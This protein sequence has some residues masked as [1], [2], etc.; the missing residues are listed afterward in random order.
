MNKIQLQKKMKMKFGS[1]SNFAR[2]VKPTD[3][4]YRYELQK[5]FARVAPSV[6]ELTKIE[7]L[8]T[9]T[10]KKPSYRNVDKAKIA[11][12]V[13]KVNEAGGPVKF[14]ADNVQFNLE[15]VKHIMYKG[16]TVMGK[17]LRELFDHFEIK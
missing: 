10:D 5:L 13:D 14:C 2:T 8:I 11:L 17:K 6:K 9:R 3:P 7:R 4:K 12:L 16:R 15:T 1:M